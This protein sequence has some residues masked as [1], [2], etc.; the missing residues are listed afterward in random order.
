MEFSRSK[1]RERAA[2]FERIP[3]TEGAGELESHFG[4]RIVYESGGSAHNC[5]RVT[6]LSEAQPVF[7]HAGICIFQSVFEEF[8][9][10]RVQTIEGAKRVQPRESV[11][12]LLGKIF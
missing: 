8:G 7:A 3:F 10:E 5:G 2:C 4:R 9:R 1:L 6:R 12:G 11:G